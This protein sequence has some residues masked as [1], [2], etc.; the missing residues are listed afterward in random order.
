[1]PQNGEINQRFG[2]YKTLCCNAE[3]VIAVGS[4]FPDCPH[5]SKLTTIWKAKRGN[6]IGETPNKPDSLPV[7]E[8]HIE[9]RR[10]FGL[11]SGHLMVDEWE[12]EHLHRCKVCKGVLCVFL[13]QPIKRLTEDQ[14]KP[15]KA[16]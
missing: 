14:P 1:V 13:N 15:G 12:E 16:A 4:T 2:H 6:L 9:N 11:A 3:M 8:T 7:L 5:H 10:L